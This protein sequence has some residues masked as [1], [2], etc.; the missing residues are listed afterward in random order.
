MEKQ[1]EALKNDVEIVK[2]DVEIVK[3][4]IETIKDEAKMLKTKINFVKHFGY[5]AGLSALYFTH[6]HGQT[7]TKYNDVCIMLLF[8]LLI[9]AIICF[10]LDMRLSLDS[11]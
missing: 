4:D 9:A 6:I 10:F 3:D 8:C 11:E 7:T 1:V 5:C 2:D